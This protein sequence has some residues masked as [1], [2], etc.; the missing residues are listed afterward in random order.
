[1]GPALNRLRD[2]VNRVSRE[3]VRGAAWSAE[4][5]AKAVIEDQGAG[6]LSCDS[7]DDVVRLIVSANPTMGSLSNLA[8]AVREACDRG[9]T[10]A[11]GARAFLDYMAWSRQRMVSRSVELARDRPITVIT[12]SFS[13]AVVDVLSSLQGRVRRVYV[14]E[15]QPGGE[16]A[17]AA[18]ELRSRGVDSQLIPDAMISTYVDQSDVVLIGADNVTIDGCVYNKV[19]SKNLAI[20]AAYSGKPVVAAFEPYKIVSEG[21]CGKVRLLE[22]SYQAPPW[23]EVRYLV[24]DE[25]TRDLIDS[26]LSVNG[27]GDNTPTQLSAL[28]RSFEEWVDQRLAGQ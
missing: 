3:Q 12:I 22:R 21:Q 23:G 18:S 6:A 14:M 1:M 11:D 17:Y 20:V 13:S 7:A 8:W 26:I 10:P 25:M 24:F 28:R 27:L 5:L 16:G 15:S 19:G 9:L 4:E 2:A